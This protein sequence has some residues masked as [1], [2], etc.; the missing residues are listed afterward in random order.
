MFIKKYRVLFLFILLIVLFA[1]NSGCNE[2]INND[3]GSFEI[4]DFEDIKDEK[5]YEHINFNWDPYK[6]SDFYRMVYG[7]KI[8]KNYYLFIEAILSH[9]ESFKC[10]DK[11]SMQIISKLGRYLFPP[12]TKLVSGM[13]YKDGYVFMTYHYEKS[14]SEKVLKQ[15][16]EKITNIIE[17]S[18]MKGDS[19]KIIAISLYYKY[20]NMISYDYLAL[21]SDKR[22]DISSYRALMDF[23]GNCQS[24]ARAYAYLCLQCDIDA[25]SVSGMN[26]FKA[27]EWTMIKLGDKYYYLDPTFENSME[28][29]GLRY[30]GM[31]SSEREREGGF[32]ADE[33]NIGNSNVIFGRDITVTDEEFAVL[34]ESKSI[35]YMERI[36]G[37]LHIRG[38]KI[39]GSKFEFV[40]E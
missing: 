31:T 15:F 32:I 17:S 1:I 13:E 19:K 11:K 21:N 39:D 2:K 38:N 14:E 24:F 16:K 10:E 7:R 36:N 4:D 29:I 37:S 20:S 28:N 33:Y 27:H 3:K 8:E 26:N 22:T 34:W 12:F 9:D 23:K 6:Y 18:V 25:V 5:F 35:S 40:V 30:F